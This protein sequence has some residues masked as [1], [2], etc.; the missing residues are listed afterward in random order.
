M[1]LA[2]KGTKKKSNLVKSCERCLAKRGTGDRCT[3]RRRPGQMFCGTHCKSTPNGVVSSAD[4]DLEGWEKLEVYVEIN[5]GIPY[6]IDSNM[7]VYHYGDILERAHNPRRV[8][9]MTE[10]DGT[11]VFVE[12][13]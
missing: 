10:I 3:R 7:N 2:T 9:K 11:T 4:E 8:G 13:C 5:R 1:S 6:F 12:T